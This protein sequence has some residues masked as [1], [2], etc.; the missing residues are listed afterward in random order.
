MFRDQ[1]LVSVIDLDEDYGIA[2]FRSTGRLLGGL[3]TIENSGGEVV[4][5]EALNADD[6]GGPRELELTDLAKSFV[7]RL[8]FEHIDV[9]IVERVGKDI[10][11]V[12]IGA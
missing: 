9:L 4:G 11:G 6:I 3:A 1:W 2:G 5:V 12:G 10:S 8:P 7:P